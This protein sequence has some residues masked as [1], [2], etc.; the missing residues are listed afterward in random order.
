M[1]KNIRIT[2]QQADAIEAELDRR[3][4]SFPF[5]VSANA[6]DEYMLTID[7]YD[8]LEEKFRSATTG[9]YAAIHAIVPLYDE[10]TAIDETSVDALV[11]E[12][13]EGD[14]RDYPQTYVTEQPETAREYV[15]ARN[16]FRSAQLALNSFTD[17]GMNVPSG[18]VV[19]YNEAQTRWNVAEKAY[20][21]FIS[22]LLDRRNS[23]QVVS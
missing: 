1:N 19:N 13:A 11:E 18:V 10:A 6:K 15:V 5:V 20:Q 14:R 2:K 16:A 17:M 8:Q 22:D 7:S 3:N 4:R 23:D 21:Q 12:I 9:F